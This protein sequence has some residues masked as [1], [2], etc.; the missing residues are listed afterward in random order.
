MV[1]ADWL[2]ENGTSDA[3]AA[4]VEFIRLGFKSKAKLKITS[5]ETKWLDA[6]WMRLLVNT[7]TEGPSAPAHPQMNRSGRF[8]RLIFRWHEKER[9]R[10]TDVVLEYV[11]GFARRVEYSQGHGYQRFWRAA[12]TD[13]PLAYHRPERRPELRYSVRERAAH[14]HLFSTTWGQVVYGLAAGFDREEAAGVKVYLVREHSEQ[15]A[16]PFHPLV[17]A[18]EHGIAAPQHRQRA[19]V[20]TAMTAIAREHVGLDQ[21]L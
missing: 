8:I 20:A 7:L 16:S 9:P 12:A 4:R 10:V 18:D 17:L 19:A 2:E 11:R 13:E 6:N 1:F 15:T 21:A 14:T 5:A 3:D